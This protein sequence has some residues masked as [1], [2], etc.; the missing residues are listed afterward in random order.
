M[1]FLILEKLIPKVGELELFELD[2]QVVL[3]IEVNLLLGGPVHKIHL[4]FVGE[5]HKYI[6]V[7][8][9]DDIRDKALFM[10]FGVLGDD[11]LVTLFNVVLVTFDLIDQLIVSEQSQSFGGLAVVALNYRAKAIEV[12]AVD[13][14][15]VVVFIVSNLSDRVF[16]DNHQVL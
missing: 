4:V 12:N 5:Q 11:E 10:L 8:V 3:D 16:A 15:E 13:D 2:R 1:P 9:V 6:V 7:G 14:V